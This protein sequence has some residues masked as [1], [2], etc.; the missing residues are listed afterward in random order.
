MVVHRTPDYLCLEPVSHVAG[1]FGFPP[2][3]CRESGLA[4]LEPGQVLS[5]KVLLA[6]E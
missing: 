3:M 1:A 6:V 5:G 4:L 2:A